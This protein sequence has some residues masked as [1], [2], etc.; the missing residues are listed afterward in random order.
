MKNL[1]GLRERPTYLELIDYIENNNDKIKMPDRRA[2]FMRKSFYL[3]QL[4]G[5]GMRKQEE[6]QKLREARQEQ[7]LLIQQFA[8]DFGFVHRDIKNWLEGRGL[9]PER[10]SAAP[11]QQTEERNV[12]RFMTPQG[13]RA[14]NMLRGAMQR[15]ASRRRTQF[16]S[17]ATPLQSPRDEV[18]ETPPREREVRRSLAH[19]LESAEDVAQQAADE[20]V[21]STSVMRRAGGMLA[22]GASAAGGA[23]VSAASTTTSALASG[24]S[25]AA[26]VVLSA[27]G[28]AAGTAIGALPGA[29]TG[30]VSLLNR[31]TEGVVEGIAIGAKKLPISDIGFRRRSRSQDRSL[32]FPIGLGDLSPDEIFQMQQDMARYDPES[33][34]Y[35][36]QLH[37]I[38]PSQP[39]RQLQIPM[40]AE[41]FGGQAAASSSSSS[42]SAPAPVPAA[43]VPP[44]AATEEMEEAPENEV[45]PGKRTRSVSRQPK[46]STNVNNIESIFDP[47]LD[48]S[49]NEALRMNVDRKLRVVMKDSGE[50]DIMIADVLTQL[51]KQAAKSL[52]LNVAFRDIRK[53]FNK[54]TDP[55]DADRR[56]VVAYYTLKKLQKVK[57]LP[58]TTNIMKL[59]LEN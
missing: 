8:R 32:E 24:A 23:L 33:Y 22:S 57:N 36:P 55:N 40:Q 42:W 18:E 35:M 50:L 45:P 37:P 16:H 39:L 10:R 1:A 34:M 11:Q 56:L 5:E 43:P 48:E 14:V 38:Q 44:P 54:N 49:P 52:Q 41:V 6:M 4:D 9:V 27:V 2:T 17:M 31:I 30:T 51:S 28:T 20:G 3:S 19:E 53:R 58:D 15:R 59:K 13:Q 7:E 25:A 21:P 46:S 29:V 12:E 26:P 47:T